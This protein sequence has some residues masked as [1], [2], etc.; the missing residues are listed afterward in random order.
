M[1]LRDNILVPENIPE[2]S[3]REHSLSSLECSLSSLNLHLKTIK[4]FVKFMVENWHYLRV[5]QIIKMY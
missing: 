4:Y 5:K 3:S 1:S 2:R